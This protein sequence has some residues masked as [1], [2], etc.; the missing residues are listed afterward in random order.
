MIKLV[1]ILKELGDAS[2]K[3]FI[4]TPKFEKDHGEYDEEIIVSKFKDDENKIIT[5]F[6][7]SEDGYFYGQDS[8]HYM[9]EE[10]EYGILNVPKNYY[11]VG[12]GIENNYGSNSD[13]RQKNT[14]QYYVRLMTTIIIIIKDFV[15]K[16]DPDGLVIVKTFAD[17][18]QKDEKFNSQKERVYIAYLTQALPNYKL[19]MKGRNIF[20]DKK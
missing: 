14:L 6:F 7:Y 17:R 4:S 18:D 1:E 15:K 20:F 3:P 19:R 8:S 13:D 11:S 12:Y 5:V 16:F 2:A 10:E 9:K